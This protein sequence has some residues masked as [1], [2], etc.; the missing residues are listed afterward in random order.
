MQPQTFEAWAQHHVLALPQGAS[1]TL[2]GLLAEM[3]FT[4]PRLEDDGLRVSRHSKIL[5]PFHDNAAR[6]KLGL[7][8]ETPEL[9]VIECP[10]DAANPRFWG[11]PS[12][13]AFRGL[14]RM[15]CRYVMR[16]GF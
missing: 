14:A 13:P 4:A 5:G 1:L 15:G 12:A 10:R 11:C 2:L 6:Q 3:R 16:A 8:Q 7:P 9:F